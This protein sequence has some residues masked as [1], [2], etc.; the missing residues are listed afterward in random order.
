M[1]A[2]AFVALL[3]IGTE[4]HEARPSRL[5]NLRFQYLFFDRFPYDFSNPSNR[6]NKSPT[7]RIY[8]IVIM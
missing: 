3:L 1:C 8:N 7:L 5:K 6:I 2:V 4:S